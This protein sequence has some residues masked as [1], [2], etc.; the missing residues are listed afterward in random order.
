MRKINTYGVRMVRIF[1]E[2]IMD[3]IVFKVQRP[4]VI[5]SKEYTRPE[6]RVSTKIHSRIAICDR[7]VRH[8]VSSINDTV[9][10]CY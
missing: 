6:Y 2:K 10:G 4:D 3:L 7:L 1:I 9:F 5:R 8:H